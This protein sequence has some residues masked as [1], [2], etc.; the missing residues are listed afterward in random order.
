VTREQHSF[1][2]E[3]GYPKTKRFMISRGM[4]LE[5]AAELAQAAWAK[6]WECREQ[7]RE[8]ESLTSWINTIALNLFRNS[9][10][11][12]KKTIELPTD[13]A[14]PHQTNQE[15]IDCQRLLERCSLPDR[16]LIEGHYVLG[17]TCVELG[18]ALGCSNAAVRVRLMRLRRR[19]HSLALAA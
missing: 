3:C 2:Y 15:S 8:V 18:R 11:A 1:A 9:F 16:E 6:G 19:L 17:Y 4:S 7:V 13:L 12:E 10:R 5:S 14:A